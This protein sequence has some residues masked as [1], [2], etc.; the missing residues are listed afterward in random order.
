[1]GMIKDLKCSHAFVTAS[2]ADVQWKDL[3]R[4]MLSQ[5][6]SPDSTEQEQ[7]QLFS[8][9]LNENPAIAAY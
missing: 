1:M 2:A 5:T 3:H 4:F 8:K 7:I 6:V 9:N